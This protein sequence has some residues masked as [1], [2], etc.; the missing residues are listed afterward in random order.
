MLVQTLPRV[1]VRAWQ[2]LNPISIVRHLWRYRDLIVQMVRREVG[3]RY[4]GSY[5]GVL[6]SLITPLLM[7]A[8]YT[9]VFSTVFKARWRTDVETPPAEFALT[10]FAG[11]TAFNIFSEVVGRAPTLILAV[12]NYVKK[13]VFPLE[14]LPVV[15][16]G[17]ALVNSLISV[18]LLLIGSLV[19]LGNFSTTVV[20]LPFAYLPLILLCLGLGWFLA[21]LGVY[22][23]DIGQGIG[24]VVQMLFFLSPVFY[25]AT[26]VPEFLQSVFDFNPLTA[27]LAGFRQTLLWGQMLE[28]PSWMLW[29]L[30]TSLLAVFG[31]A[32]F[33]RTKKGFADVM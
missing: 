32:W 8:I 24:L 3:Q 29:T 33:V 30:L 31:Y 23:R 27:I 19:L 21:S 12:P 2:L 13:V 26:A 25:P 28:W 7:L 4:R 1:I 20:L 10:L 17:T 18:V 15:A 22:V 11:L 9:F 14:I 16:L 5:L 6:W